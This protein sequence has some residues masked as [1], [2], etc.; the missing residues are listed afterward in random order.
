[1]SFARLA[2]LSQ[3]HRDV[4]AL[5]D[6][7][8]GLT[9]SQLADPSFDTECTLAERLALVAAYYFREGEILAYLSGQQNDLPLEDDET[10]HL[11]AVRTRLNW[12]LTELESDLEDAWDFYGQMLR[13]SSDSDYLT[14]L[15]SRKG[16]M[17]RP[18]YELSREIGAWRM[19]S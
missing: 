1:M 8:I 13:E 12:T 5:R 2:I 6:A 3:F 14:Y 4:Q 10:W 18:A 19:R 11:E 9:N 16:I 15:Q 7:L 17:P